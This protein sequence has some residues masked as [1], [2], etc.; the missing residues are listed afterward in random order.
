MAP[1]PTTRRN[2]VDGS[3]AS[4]K[5]NFVNIQQKSFRV[6]GLT[7]LTVILAFTIAGHN[8][9]IIRSFNASTA[10]TE[11]AAWKKRTRTERRS[12]T[13]R[14]MLGVVPNSLVPDPPPDYG[15]SSSSTPSFYE[16]VIGMF[17]YALSV[18]RARKG[19]VIQHR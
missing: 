3:N 6:F 14:H 19:I 7:K 13:L 9:E 4:L 5:T 11:A 16:G 1:L 8:L 18:F 2:V 15:R 12:G 10:A 17:R